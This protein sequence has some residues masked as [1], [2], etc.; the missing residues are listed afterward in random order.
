MSDI[1]F[2]PFGPQK[3]II[4][5]TKRIIGAFAGKRS[6]KSEV[7]AVKF[8]TAVEQ[9]INY[10]P[11]GIDPY[12]GAIV[13]PTH[14]MLERLSWKKFSAYAKPFLPNGF[15]KR[16]H[17]AHW[18][19]GQTEIL[20]L[21]A[22]NP[23]RMEGIKANVIWLDEI[24][25]MSEDVFLECRARIADSKGTLICT[26]SLGVQY[27]NPKLHWA[28]KY[29]K[30]KPDKDTVC[31]EWAT[32]YNPH[33]PQDELETLKQTLD[34]ETFRAMFELN[35]DTIP[36]NAVYSDFNES[37]ILDTY[38]LNPELP[39]YCSI[40]WGYAHPMAV[41]FFQYDPRKD[42]LY[43]FDEIITSKIT[44]EQLYHKI[45]AKNYPIDDWF[46]DIAGNQEREL[47]GE[48]NIE[49]F[50]QRGIHFK[51]KSDSIQNGLSLVRSYIKTMSGERK[52]YISK[53]CKKLIDGIKQ[54][55]YPERDGM[56]VNENPIKQDDDAC[57]SLRYG[58]INL[59][60]KKSNEPRNI[61][62]R[63]R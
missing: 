60:G 34:P 51:Y 63:I 21:S 1:I 4:Q 36:K 12:I 2:R 11:N 44:I 50:K 24:F 14:D 32:K 49:W 56:I 13:A 43:Y 53:S 8:I 30:E 59:L 3:K 27:V 10:K 9:K 39:T 62:M 48:S 20:G 45:K 17:L 22:D 29:F 33:F 5:E 23:Q 18:Y 26:G 47:T 15:T 52:L 31:Y 38:T 40:D 41:L 6:G 7:G 19:D 57:D 54:Y 25:Q 28:Y 16:P 46:C 61:V 55:R 37:N 35:W 42:W 58:I